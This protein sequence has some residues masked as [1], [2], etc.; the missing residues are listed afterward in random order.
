LG[1]IA[2]RL[3]PI[4]VMLAL[5]WL[6]KKKAIMG[7]EAVSSLKGFVARVS[8]PAVVFGAFS[9]VPMDRVTGVT[10]AAVFL[11][12]SLALVAGLG[13][14]ALFKRRSVRPFLLTA[15]EAG[16]LGLPLFS[17]FYGPGAVPR[18]AMADLGEIC[19]TFLVLIPM[20][21]QRSGGERG[22]R[23][24]LARLASNPVIWSVLLGLASAATGLS[25]MLAA[26]SGGQALFSTL[27]FIGAPTGALI[28]FV[29]GYDLDFSR[30]SLG[31]AL[32]TVALRYAIMVPLFFA[33]RA[34]V[35]ALALDLVPGAAGIED[36]RIVRA[37]LMFLFLMPSTFAIP[38][39]G[40]EGEESE[41]IST[42]L[43]LN[44]LVT[45]ILLALLAGA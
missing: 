19:F 8:L 36:G 9:A 42:T 1:E 26:S 5:G 18:I 11:A 16:M 40:K 2:G 20:L 7:R 30:K 35:G 15:F 4:F 14:D 41:Y 6:F 21:N 32:P 12:C 3:A 25:R 29:V 38:V 28:L 44:T 10:F 24:A 33:V 37:A 27:S 13:I 39:F 45:V 23:P 43:S 22:I 17:I 34:A 31:A